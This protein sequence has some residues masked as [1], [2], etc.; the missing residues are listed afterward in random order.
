[1]PDYLLLKAELADPAYA[2]LSDADASAA[3]NA[4][5]RGTKRVSVSVG[6]FANFLGF[7]GLLKGINDA[8]ASDNP[9]I[10][11]AALLL[12]WKIQGQAAAV[13]DPTDDST[14][15]T[16]EAFKAAGIVAQEDIDAFGAVTTVPV[17]VLDLIGW[18]PT[19]EADVAHARKL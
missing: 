17:K 12:M 5:T 16:F 14:T 4:A 13:I 6:D 1:M 18:P 19:T 9:A 3:V 10:A 15:G 8:R 2:G 11:S 7:R